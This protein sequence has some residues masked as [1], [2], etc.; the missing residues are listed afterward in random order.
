MAEHK[1]SLRQIRRINRAFDAMHSRHAPDSIKSSRK[2]KR[3]SSEQDAI[4]ADPYEMEGGFLPE[5]AVDLPQL[6]YQAHADY[7]TLA[8]TTDDDHLS[9]E[10]IPDALHRLRLDPHDEEVLQIFRDAALNW[11]HEK[12]NVTDE[13]PASAARTS[14]HGKGKSLEREQE[15]DTSEADMYISRDDWV[16]VCAILVQQQDLE[17]QRSRNKDVV[18][19]RPHA[20]S[21]DEGVDVSMHSDAYTDHEHDSESGSE[22]SEES[23]YS[24]EASSSGKMKPV[25][26]GHSSTMNPRQ[27]KAARQIFEMFLDVGKC[28]NKKLDASSIHRISTLVEGGK[29]Q[30][31]LKSEVRITCWWR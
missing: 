4:E 30:S 27:V 6:P 14:R 3:R 25:A 28:K 16:A 1:A 26:V 23:D 31:L 2:R 19:K 13:Q 22:L 17:R 8:R 5:D 18:K 21:S 7:D 29:Q 11:R 12:S 10:R 20:M 24:P 15:E 9:F